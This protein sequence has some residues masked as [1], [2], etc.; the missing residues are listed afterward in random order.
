VQKVASH[1]LLETRQNTRDSADPFND[2]I[3]FA[4]ASGISSCLKKNELEAMMTGTKV[5]RVATLRVICA[6][7]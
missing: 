7:N 1:K 3:A 5:T 4:L 2:V 6:C